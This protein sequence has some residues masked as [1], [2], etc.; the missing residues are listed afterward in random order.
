MGQHEPRSNEEVQICYK[1]SCDGEVVSASRHV[2]YQTKTGTLGPMGEAVDKALSTMKRGEECVLTCKG[3]YSL[4]N[5]GRFAGKEAKV[6]LILEQIYEVLDVSLGERDRTVMK[7]RVVE[8]EGKHKV[9][10]TAH[11][12]LRV[13]SVLCGMDSSPLQAGLPKE[14]SFVAGDGQ[15][16]DAIECSVLEMRKTETALIRCSKPEMC[17]GGLL[18]L[19]APLQQPVLIKVM[20]LDFERVPE[21]WDMSDRQ[22]I[23]HCRARKEVAGRLFKEGRLLL[24]ANHYATIAEFF[25]AADKWKNEEDLREGRELRRIGNLNRAMCMLKLKDWK[26]ARTL[27]DAVIKEDPENAKAYFRRGTANLELKEYACA[28]SDLQRVMDIEPSSAEGKRLLAQAKRLRKDSDKRQ[29]PV[30]GGMCKAFGQMPDRTDRQDD[31]LVSMPDHLRLNYRPV[32]APVSQPPEVAEAP[33]A[34]GPAPLPAASGPA[35][36]EEPGTGEA[37]DAGTGEAPDVMELEP[38]D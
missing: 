5:E 37:P 16:C 33:A 28:V 4:G 9:R 13:E 17:Y 35:P 7:K 11:V 6:T 18:G 20:L 38:A 23:E 34:S 2:V 15:V 19:E 12:T 31:Q 25:E 27:C 21:R 8:G 3:K 1:V 22:R 29:S 10:D 30:F 32:P 24:A 26:T 36:L 14:L